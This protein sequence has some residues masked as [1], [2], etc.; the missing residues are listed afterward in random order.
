[1]SS[2]L[3]D[4]EGRES[5]RTILSVPASFSNNVALMKQNVIV[6]LHSGQAAMH[7]SCIQ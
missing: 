5:R 4:Q 1:M 7:L 2:E 6:E 3:V